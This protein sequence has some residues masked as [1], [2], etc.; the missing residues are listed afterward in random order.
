LGNK[1]TN[2][3]ARAFRTPAPVQQ[4]AKP[5]KTLKKASTA[6]KSVK[7]KIRVAPSEPV[8]FNVLS[9][10]P[11]SD[12]PDIEYCP[13]HPVE[14]PDPPE[15]ITYDDTFPYLRGK[16]LCAG[17]GEVYDVPRDEHGLTLQERKDQEAYAKHMKDF[18]DKW[19]E[20][21]K[22]PF[23]LED[24]D[25]IVDNMIAA[26][27][28]KQGS[29]IDTIRA[30]NAVSV[31][32]SKP[33][34]RLPSAAMK[35]TASSMQKKKLAHN[36]KPTNPS[37]MRHNAA[38]AASR[39]TL[40]YSKGRNVSA[41]LSTKRLPVPNIKAGNIDPSTIH[42]QEFKELCG[43][44]PIG[45]KMWQRFRAYGLFDNEEG[46]ED[47][48]ADQLYGMDMQSEEEDEVFQLP[49]PEGVEEL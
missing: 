45:S 28:K 48:L 33:Q 6:R 18:E 8:D 22:K 7:S 19:L 35:E 46:D 16:N 36:P 21:L 20:E 43:E 15:D 14:L 31:L 12:V 40:G 41:N 29:N 42:P 3:K 10:D 24:E 26:G 4:T 11:E 27:P 30:R 1:T 9:N 17:Y 49:M 25:G 34:T 23:Q 13:P 44:L 37:L 47:D 5:E 38:V 2:A 39:T 32:S